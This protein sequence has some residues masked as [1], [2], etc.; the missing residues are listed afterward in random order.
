MKSMSMNGSNTVNGEL[1]TD[2]MDNSEAALFFVDFRRLMIASG[3]VPDI[4][5]AK[6][7]A[8]RGLGRAKNLTVKRVRKIELRRRKMRVSRRAW[9]EKV[10]NW[11]MLRFELASKTMI[12]NAI[13]AIAVRN[14]G[15]KSKSGASLTERWPM[16]TPAKSKSIIFCIPSLSAKREQ[17]I[18][19]ISTTTRLVINVIGSMIASF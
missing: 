18:P 8:A 1:M 17:K 12:A 2:S 9:I 4:M 14:S 7:S 3:A 11:W 19:M 13:I 10:S 5:K 16:M 6:S 15:G